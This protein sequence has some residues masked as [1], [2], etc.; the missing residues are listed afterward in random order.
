MVGEGARVCFCI[1]DDVFDF[2]Q[3]RVRDRHS[4]QIVRVRHLKRTES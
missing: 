1:L 4:V 2:M 3:L